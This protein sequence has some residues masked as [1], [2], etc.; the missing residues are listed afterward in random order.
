MHISDTYTLEGSPE[1]L[2]RMLRCSVAEVQSTIS[3]LSAAG[4]ADVM[5]R[6]G[7]FTLISRRRKREIAKRLNTRERVRKHRSNSDVTLYDSDSECNSS[8]FGNGGA[9]GKGILPPE[10]SE[11]A[12]FVHLWREFVAQRIKMRK[13]M[14]D[15]AARQAIAKL[16]AFGLDGAKNSLQNSIVGEWQGVFPPDRSLKKQIEPGDNGFVRKLDTDE[17]IHALIDGNGGPP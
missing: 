7:I 17:E 4:A 9:G 5:E 13:P 15:G 16:M 6:N 2:S 14:T 1:Q 8:A 11:D 12:E 10:F 3:D